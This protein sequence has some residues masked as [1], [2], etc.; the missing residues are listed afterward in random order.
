M[1]IG[2]SA[3]MA[4][5]GLS[6]GRSRLDGGGQ[7]WRTVT[8]AMD[9][10]NTRVYVAISSSGGIIDHVDSDSDMA[11]VAVTTIKRRLKWAKLTASDGRLRTCGM[12][13]K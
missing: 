4:A 12:G 10:L 5:R 6:I 1:I 7:R 8:V 13:L 11:T 3:A 2:Y 9:G